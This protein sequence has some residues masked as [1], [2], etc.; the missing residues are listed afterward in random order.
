MRHVIWGKQAQWRLRF[1][2]PRALFAP[3][4]TI[5]LHYYYRAWNRVLIQVKAQQFVSFRWP[6]VTILLYS[7]ILSRNFFW[8]EVNIRSRVKASSSFISSAK[9]QREQNVINKPPNLYP[10]WPKTCAWPQIH[11]TPIA[12]ASN[13]IHTSP[14][15]SVLFKLA[16]MYSFQ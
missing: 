12:Q 16:V 7:L 13:P 15:L 6:I 2:Q 3:D 5:T 8:N 4:F 11:R 10:P 14:F 9:D 1:P